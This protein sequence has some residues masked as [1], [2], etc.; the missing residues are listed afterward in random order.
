MA[1]ARTVARALAAAGCKTFFVATLDEA[2]ATRARVAAGPIY[3]L[4]CFFQNC[5]TPCQDRR[6]AVIA[7][8][9]SLPNGMFLPALGLGGRGAIHIDTG[10]NRS[11]LRFTEAQGIVPR[12][13]AG[14]HASRW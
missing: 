6:Q 7:I 8:S 3:V 13:N 12:I 9:T 11:A 5:A 2:R 4:G 14:D 10:M 1:A